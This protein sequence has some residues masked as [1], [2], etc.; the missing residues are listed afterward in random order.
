MKYDRRAFRRQRERPSKSPPASSNGPLRFLLEAIDLLVS[1]IG[2]IPEPI[3]NR[4]E[5][6]RDGDLAGLVQAILALDAFL[7]H[8]QDWKISLADIEAFPIL[9]TSHAGIAKPGIGVLQTLALANEPKL[10]DAE[11]QTHLATLLANQQLDSALAEVLARPVNSSL[12][13]C[14][15]VSLWLLG[16]LAAKG[17]SVHALLKFCSDRLQAAELTTSESQW[18]VK[19]LRLSTG[20][21]TKADS[22]TAQAQ[23][24]DK[25]LKALESDSKKSVSLLAEADGV[26]AVLRTWLGSL[27]E[28]VERSTDHA[29]VRQR[30]NKVMQSWPQGAPR[31]DLFA[32]TAEDLQSFDV[33]RQGDVVYRAVEKLPDPSVLSFIDRLRFEITKT[34]A[35]VAMAA[36]TP[37]SELAPRRLALEALCK[38]EALMEHGVPPAHR[39]VCQALKPNFIELYVEAAD[40]LRMY[41]LNLDETLRLLKQHPHDARLATLAVGGALLAGCT[42]RV[43]F[44]EDA[45]AR[46]EFNVNLVDKLLT[47]L[48]RVGIWRPET[49]RSC[50]F[51]GLARD[52]LRQIYLRR[53]ASALSSRNDERSL[54][55]RWPDFDRLTKLFD[56]DAL[57]WQDLNRGAEL[58]PEMVFWGALHARKTVVLTAERKAQFLK[59]ALQQLERLISANM[60][61][62]LLRQYSN[63]WSDDDPQS[64]LLTW[65]RAAKPALIEAAYEW[66]APTLRQL[67]LSEAADAPVLVAIKAALDTSEEGRQLW[68]LTQPERRKG[69]HKKPT[70]KPSKASQARTSKPKK[71]DF[72]DEHFN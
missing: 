43:K 16:L 37:P 17:L 34:R 13:S 68:R 15:P 48:D 6:L 8:D 11:T 20:I 33:I 32:Y 35:I 45:P 53:C 67:R 46:E 64:M 50:L 66:T 23:D 1:G 36:S 62:S 28:Q 14:F 29:T 21:L 58:A 41:K 9:S 61:A 40:A 22:P 38:L 24:L 59:G 42:Q 52:Q 57:V 4:I 65:C 56:M 51:A 12:A 19:I 26:I 60:I 3:R 63:L 10:L 55:Q 70:S 54:A 31:R 39:A 47:V 2:T 72:W 30:I 5:S 18:L 7:Y 69:A 49:L 27:L 25:L 44:L 71:R